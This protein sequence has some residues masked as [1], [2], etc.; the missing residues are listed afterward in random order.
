MIKLNKCAINVVTC[1]KMGDLIHLAVE[2]IGFC[3]EAAWTFSRQRTGL[4]GINYF[5]C[6]VICFCCLI[7][8]TTSG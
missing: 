1:M 2:E 3:A 7:F 5:Y 6:F 8:W 4:T